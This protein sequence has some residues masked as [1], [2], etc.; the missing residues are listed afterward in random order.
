MSLNVKAGGV[1]RNCK[2]VWVR[3]G[4]T[5]RQ[6]FASTGIVQPF[7]AWAVSGDNLA[8]S[9]SSSSLQF[10]TDGTMS[11]SGSVTNNTVAGSAN[12]YLPTTT[13]IGTG[14]WIR[15][16]VTAGTIT[17][18]SGTGTWLQLTS[19]RS[20]GKSAASGAASATLTLEIATD[21]LGASIV[22]T[23]TGNTVAYT[24]S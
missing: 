10:N 8:G 19:A 21:S 9:T 22:F 2:S 6:V 16:T 15:A 1:F 18:G 11:G 4:G 23:S 13:S 20:W 14:F 24:H 5:W 3:A 7:T 17:S 12:W